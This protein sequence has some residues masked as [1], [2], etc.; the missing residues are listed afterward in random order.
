MATPPITIE[1]TTGSCK[2]LVRGKRSTK[3]WIILQSK[4]GAS[5]PIRLGHRKL[6]EDAIQYAQDACEPD[7]RSTFIVQPSA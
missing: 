3:G 1:I 6:K 4:G 2:I 5:E 7:T